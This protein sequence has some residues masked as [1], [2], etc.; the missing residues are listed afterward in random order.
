MEIPPVSIDTEY[1]K[2]DS[3]T[4]MQPVTPICP[5]SFDLLIACGTISLYLSILGILGIV[6]IWYQPISR[7]E[8]DVPVT[9][10]CHST[11]YFGM[12]SLL[13]CHYHNTTHTSECT[14]GCVSKPVTFSG[15]PHLAML[16]RLTVGMIMYQSSQCVSVLSRCMRRKRGLFSWNS[17]EQV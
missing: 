12:P 11:L 8:V 10:N 4:C 3:I 16:P 15:I 14:F 1:P 5:A 17:H 2:L 9:H 13:L 6:C 7:W